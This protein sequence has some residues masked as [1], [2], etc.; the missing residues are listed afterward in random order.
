MTVHTNIDRRYRRGFAF[1]CIAMAIKTV[2]LVETRVY[3]MGIINGLLWLHALLS[4]QPD[5]SFGYI[6]TPN[7]KQNDRHHCDVYF[8]TIKGNRIWALNTFG[9]IRHFFQ[10]TIYLH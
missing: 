6:K 3:S 10:V 5:S 2:D 7:N 9:I 1:P 4:L 8:V